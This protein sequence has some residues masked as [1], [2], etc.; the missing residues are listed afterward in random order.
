MGAC[1]QEP[2]GG[3]VRAGELAIGAGTRLGPAE[4]GLAASLGHDRLT[5]GIRPRVAVLT[6]G[7]ELIDPGSEPES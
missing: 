7:D 5:V 2:P 3:D 6:T 1:G 4:L